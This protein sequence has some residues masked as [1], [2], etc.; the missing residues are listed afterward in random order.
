[1]EAANSAFG[2]LREV[3][4]KKGYT[5]SVFAAASDAAEYLCSGIKSK[6]VGIGGSMTIKEMGLYEKLRGS[7]EV[8]W[9]WQEYGGMSAKEVLAKAAAADVYL[10]SA[11]GVA[12]TGEI[13]NIDGNGNRVSATLYGHEKVYII[14]GRNKIAP[15]VAAALDRARNVAAP[16][17]AAR[18]G[19]RTPCTAGEQRCLDCNSPERICAAAVMFYERP[20][21]AKYEV[22][23]IDEELGY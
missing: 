9:H 14:V 18:L 7:N 19:R 11:N 1:M 13:I 15:T 12:E 20:R 2:R 10:S 5:V 22:V 3:L 4:E 6:T 23:L 8:Y 21:G 17:N 16:L